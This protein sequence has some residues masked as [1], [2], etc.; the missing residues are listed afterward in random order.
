MFE[1]IERPSV[2][3]PMRA[4]WGARLA[5]RVNELCAATSPGMLVRE[6]LGGSG[7]EPIPQSRRLPRAASVQPWTFVCKKSE[8]EDGKEKREGGWVNCKVQIG[9]KLIEVEEG[10]DQTDDGTY[11]CVCDLTNDTA[12]VELTGG[13]DPDYVEGYDLEKNTLSFV[14]GTVEDGEQKSG[15]HMHPVAY[16]VL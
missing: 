5:D 1:T 12:K 11:L 10:V 16:K 13:D 7:A 2:G 15:P 6:G 4:A 14:V 3:K 8:G 9:Y